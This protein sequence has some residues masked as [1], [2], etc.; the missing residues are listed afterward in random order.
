MMPQNIDGSKKLS[1]FSTNRVLKIVKKISVKPHFVSSNNHDGVANYL[2]LELKKLGLE[3]NFEEDFT[4]TEWGNLTKSKNIIAKIKGSDSSKTLLLLS[5]YDSAP[6]SLSNGASDD[7]SGV[8]TILESIRAF[9]SSN[10]KHKNDIIILFT[11]A[12]ELGLNGAALFVTK[13][14]LCKDVGLA[15]NFEARGTSGPSFMLMEVNKGNAKMVESFANANPKEAVSNSLMYSIYKML[16]NDTDLTVFREHGQIQG[17]NFAFIDNHFNY[18]TSQDTYENLNPKSL[19]Q[20][21]SYLMPMLK[22]FA[23]ADL[24]NMN[25][26][27]DLV[28]FT[29]P[30]GFF[31]YSFSWVLPI[32]IVITILFLFLIFLAIGKRLINLIDAAKGFL[33]LMFAILLAGS[34]TFFG[35]K[36]ILIVYPQYN[37]ILQGFTYNGHDYVFGFLMLSLSI[38]FWIYN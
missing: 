30:I 16:P 20:Q 33:L 37:D 21:G 5:H 31:H 27:E 18:H 1:E 12:E 4:L 23:N 13:N 15:I 11:D 14:K 3:T 2:V 24:K 32:I 10:Q 7:A 25:S 22:Y 35:W 9:K 26:I 36:L 34:T 28:Y 29:T 19:A 8:A 17:F 38:C 6:H